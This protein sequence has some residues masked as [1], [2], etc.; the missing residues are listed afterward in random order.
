V[1]GR[2]GAR[3]PPPDL[4]AEMEAAGAAGDDVRLGLAR[5]RYSAWLAD[6]EHHAE[7][8]DLEGTQA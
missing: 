1:S 4:W 7:P 5:A 3:K 8:L 2:H 6:E